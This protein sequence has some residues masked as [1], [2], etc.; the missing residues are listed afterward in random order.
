MTRPLFESFD[1]P[2]PSP[3]L[4]AA[5]QALWWIRKGNFRLGDEWRRAH[6]ICQGAE[7]DKHHDWIH[8]L[9]HLIE[10]DHANAAYWYRRAGETQHSADPE[11][12]WTHIAGRLTER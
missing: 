9:V 5:Q 11:A 12:E 1:R 3:E 10:E 8:A 2:A 7:G 4:S 6:E